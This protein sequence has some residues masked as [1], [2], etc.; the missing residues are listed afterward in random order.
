MA[1]MVEVCRFNITLQILF[2]NS[3]RYLVWW[4][5][6]FECSGLTRLGFKWFQ[7]EEASFR[8]RFAPD[9]EIP[10]SH[11]FYMYRFILQQYSGT[12]LEGCILP[13]VVLQILAGGGGKEEKEYMYS[14]A[15]SQPPA[16]SRNCKP[17]QSKWSLRRIG[18]GSSGKLSTSKYLKLFEFIL[19]RMENIWAVCI[20]SGQ[21]WGE[22][23]GLS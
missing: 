15:S 11:S 3:L 5:R 4:S 13:F 19:K 18:G 23:A 21:V 17:L 1:V 12:V 22:A 8:T 10:I 6:I 9:A 14:F 7:I 16:K 20:T 2:G